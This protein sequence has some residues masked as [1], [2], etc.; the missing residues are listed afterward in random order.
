MY[1]LNLWGEV[2]EI[3]LRLDMVA[4]SFIDNIYDLFT[5]IASESLIS[6]TVIKQVLSNIYV[7]VGIFAFFRLAVLLI[8]SIIN[9]D[10]LS[11]SGAGLSRLFI[12]MVLMLV[13]LVFTPTLFQMSRDLAK[14]VVE[15]NYIQRLFINVNDVEKDFSPGK[16]MQRIAIGSVLTIDDS[17]SESDCTG[18]CDKAKQC[19]DTINGVE[20]ATGDECL[21]D[22]GVAWGKLADYNSV[23][24]KNSDGEK[25]YVYNYKP[26]VL[27]IVGWFITYVLLSFTFDVAKRMIELA[28]LEIV[29]PLFIATIVDPKSMQTGP[30]HKWLKTLGNSYVSL[31]LRI[32]AISLMLLAVKLLTLWKPQADVGA[33]GKVI[34]LIAFLIFVKQL[35]KWFSDMIGIDGDG[36]GLG[37]LGIGK[38]I[39]GAAV[40]G[41]LATKA[42]H[43]LAGVGTGAVAATHN[44]LRNR[45]AERKG[46][47][48]DNGL[49]KGIGRKARAA[50]QNYYAD[51]GL[52][53]ASYAERRKSLAK[54][55]SDA[56]KDA[57]AGV[58]N[59][60]GFKQGMQQ[61]GSSI[62]AGG[63]AGGKAGISA[64]NMKGVFQGS[65]SSA[66]KF[67]EE[68]GLK[69]KGIG[70]KITDAIDNKYLSAKGAYGTAAQ[71]QDK[72]DDAKKAS[73]FN[74]FFN[75]KFKANN[76]VKDTPVGQ[77]AFNASFQGI[78][79]GE[80]AMFA[81]LGLKSGLQNAKIK[82][83]SD[84]KISIANDDTSYVL[85]GKEKK[86]YESKVVNGQETLVEKTD[87]NMNNKIQDGRNIMTEEGLANYQNMFAR[88]QS[89]AISSMIGNN[90]QMSALMQQ[91]VN[92]EQSLSYNTNQA[93]ATLAAAGETEV[94]IAG[95]GK[96]KLADATMD[97]IKEMLNQYRN[98]GSDA[99]KA[100]ASNCEQFTT[101][102]DKTSAN[103][104]NI[105][106]QLGYYES[107][108]EKLKNMVE[109]FRE[110]DGGKNKDKTLDELLVI[111]QKNQE[112][113]E[114]AKKA[115]DIQKKEK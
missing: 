92:A 97:Q 11:K 63:I 37:S 10:A 34:I 13:L 8:N 60:A 22:K 24:T 32:A 21:N 29:S 77:G 46:I 7:V 59:A 103:I 1:I 44:Q 94:S 105:N 27:T 87:F 91:R 39:G 43:T 115:Y 52:S 68:V 108:N 72:I 93:K 23:R 16:E 67:G 33:I 38:K 54:A 110:A 47:R 20:G 70:Q 36:T 82:A 62:V 57:N 25:V 56:Y 3:F 89:D 55:R 64:D 90:S 102:Y 66:N 53:D 12:N 101:S 41:G 2:R 107:S 71:I 19:L 109:S 61:L 104:T 45:R 65:I 58:F 18:D 51:H 76:S 114:K 99:Q 88:A 69:G 111:A 4:F 83:M 81:A 15:G 48:D 9:P 100:V 79:G 73:N 98:T 35:P 74:S 75:D 113:A 26:L 30:F 40:I 85:D 5:A 106:Q 112:D 95:G 50:R 78:S 17:I 96:I 31:F 42:G 80:D 49:N 86:L 28:V 84:G 14:E 6:D